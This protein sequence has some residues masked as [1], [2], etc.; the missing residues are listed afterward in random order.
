MAIPIL[1]KDVPEWEGKYWVSNTGIVKGRRGELKQ[2]VS[3]KGYRVVS[4]ERGAKKDG[5]RHS[6]FASVHR[7]VAMA[8]IPNPDNLPQ[9]NHIDENPNNNNAENLEWCT[10]KYNMNYGE[11]AKTRRLKIDYSAQERKDIARE[12]GKKTTSKKVIQ[13]TKEGEVI[14]MYNSVHEAS[15]Y[16]GIDMSHISQVA[17]N[18]KNRSTAGGFKWAFSK[19]GVL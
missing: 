14:K 19:G 3:D 1:W 6:E 11:G 8:F 17:N 4:L 12:N 18:I 9:V 16:T 7:L 15:R 2:W 10:P 13:L 5:T